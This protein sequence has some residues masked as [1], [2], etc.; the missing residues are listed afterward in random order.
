MSDFFLIVWLIDILINWLIHYLT[1]WLTL[2]LTDWLTDWLT[3]SLTD[4]LT[5]W[6][7]GW[8]TDSLTDSLTLSLTDWLTDSLVDTIILIILLVEETA[9][10]KGIRR[11]TGITGAEAVQAQERGNLLLEEVNVIIGQLHELINGNKGDA[12]ALDSAVIS[13]RFVGI[14]LLIIMF[15][16]TFCSVYG[17]EFFF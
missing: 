16:N 17:Q 13:L 2:S 10:A 8:L 3:L 6:L 5:D 9:V 1:D 12:L 11:V 14:H 4:S 7:T 15:E